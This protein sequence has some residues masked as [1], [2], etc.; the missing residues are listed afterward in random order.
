MT[1]K[2]NCTPN[3]IIDEIVKSTS[4]RDEL[5]SYINQLKRVTLG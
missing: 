2:L 5:I 1:T 3:T 4:Q